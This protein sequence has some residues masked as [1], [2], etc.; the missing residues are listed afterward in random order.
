M[1]FIKF[2]L[3]L[4]QKKI[5]CGILETLPRFFQNQLKFVE[6]KG[7]ILKFSNFKDC[8]KKCPCTLFNINFHTFSGKSKPIVLETLLE[9]LEHHNTQQT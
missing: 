1:D 8:Q 5:F 2:H 6:I 3:K 9:Y 7:N 4:R